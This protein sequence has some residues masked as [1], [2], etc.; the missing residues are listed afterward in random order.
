M[1]TD[2]KPPSLILPTAQFL[3]DWKNYYPNMAKK[4]PKDTSYY[5]SKDL[6]HPKYKHLQRLHKKHHDDWAV[7]EH[8]WTNNVK[9]LCLNVATCTS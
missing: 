6:R 2:P 7:H 9:A 5:D 3:S 1:A 8:L 4:Q